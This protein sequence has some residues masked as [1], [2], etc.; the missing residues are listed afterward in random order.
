MELIQELYGIH[1]G[2]PDLPSMAY[3]SHG[4][5]KVWT[6]GQATYCLLRGL[7]V[8]AIARENRK[9]SGK[10]RL[11]PEEFALHSG[12]IGGATRLAAMGASSRV[13]QREER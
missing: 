13:I 10:A 12:R 9:E 7:S 3:R 5:W 11:V 4:G 2:R 1:G 8:V 6:R